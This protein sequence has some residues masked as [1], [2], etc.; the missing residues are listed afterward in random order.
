MPLSPGVSKDQRGQIENY[1]GYIEVSVSI[2]A[3]NFR[4]V[5]ICS[6]LDMLE[7]K[8][9]VLKRCS[10]LLFGPVFVSS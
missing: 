9:L 3:R 8:C 7:C 1:R 5:R 6:S 10:P 2:N 4:K